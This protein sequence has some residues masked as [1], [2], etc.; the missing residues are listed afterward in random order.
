MGITFSNLTLKLHAGIVL[1]LFFLSSDYFRKQ[2]CKRSFKT[3]IRVSNSLD[4]VWTDLGPNCLQRSLAD[5]TSSYRVNT[6][7]IQIS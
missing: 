1:M 2:L 6:V 4:P 5:E 7:Y 3:F